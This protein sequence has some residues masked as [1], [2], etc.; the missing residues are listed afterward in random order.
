M[1]SGKSVGAE[2]ALLGEKAR[3]KK[4][5]NLKAQNV[6]I[7]RKFVSWLRIWAAKTEFGEFGC[8]TL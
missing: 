1:G 3:V 8:A 6:P 5:Y 2:Q 4:N 7:L